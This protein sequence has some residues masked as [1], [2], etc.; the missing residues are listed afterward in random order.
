L[1]FL[2]ALPALD[3]D[4]PLKNIVVIFDR[5]L[6]QSEPRVSLDAGPIPGHLITV[7]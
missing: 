3:K 6:E 7:D 1:D 2:L 4:L 5:I